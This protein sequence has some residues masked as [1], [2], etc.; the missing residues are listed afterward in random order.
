MRAATERK[1]SIPSS[2][3]QPAKL[4]GLEQPLAKGL[5]GAGDCN[6]PAAVDRDIEIKPPIDAQTVFGDSAALARCADTVIA[7]RL[8]VDSGVISWK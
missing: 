1:A 5:R 3:D 2:V 7:D 4:V 6:R 8:H